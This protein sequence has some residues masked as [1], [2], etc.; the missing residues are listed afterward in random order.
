MIHKII[1]LRPDNH[2]VT[3]ETFCTR[4][5]EAHDTLPRPAI[6]VCPGGAYEWCCPR[7]A[8]PVALRLLPYGFQTFVLNYSIGDKAV[9]PAPLRDLSKAVCHVR[10]NAE[11]YNVDPDK[12]FVMGFSAGGHL[13]AA[14]GVFWNTEMAQ[15]DGMIKG[16]NKPTGVAPCFPVITADPATGH[17][18]SYSKI[19]GGDEF[20]DSLADKY[21]P[22]L[23]VSE[24]TVPMFLWHTFEDE[25]VPVASSLIM[26]D[27]LNRAKIPF[28]LHIFPH[29]GHGMVLANEESAGRNEKLVDPHTAKWVEMLVCWLRER[30]KE[31]D[32]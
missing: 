13:S 22:S 9:Y 1:N 27:A 8:E 28:E 31:I 6:I 29:G 25:A 16:S 21:N 18:Y 19:C 30:C 20:V 3:L 5:G 11:E 7:D 32:G 15:F 23:H 2:M 14:Y 26:A 24:D 10:D 17:R 4:M 12:I